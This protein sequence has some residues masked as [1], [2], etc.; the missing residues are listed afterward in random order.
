[1]EIAWPTVGS[2]R[3]TKMRKLS[4]TIL[5]LAFV[6]AVQ[7]YAQSITGSLNGRIVDQQGS[8][9]PNARVTATEPTKKLTV[10]T[11]STG[12]GD[13]SIAGLAPGSYTV[14]VEATG[15]KKLTRP[16]VPLNASDK[17]ALGDLIVQIGALT[18]TVEVS[19]TAMTLQT[20]SSERGSAVT[21]T[22]ISNINVDGRIALD[23]AKLIPG[24]QFSTGATYAV[25]GANGGN[26]FTANGTR[27]SQNQV[28]IDRK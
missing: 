10:G 19:A 22:Q 4:T 16:D 21:G 14:S 15:F 26:Q 12:A 27:P 7:G 1:M 8:A 23:L 13:F 6:L 18:E 5:L 2:E 25:G 28:T 17:I 9:V 20:E 3:K 24:V 11:N